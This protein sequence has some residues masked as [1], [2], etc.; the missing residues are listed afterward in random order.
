MDQRVVW[1]VEDDGDVARQMAALLADAGFGV[2]VFPDGLSV[3]N[4]F[5]GDAPDVLL[6]DWNLPDDA[7][8]SICRWVRRH[9]EALPVM[10]VTVRD[11][12]ADIVEGLRAG[13]DDYVTKPF[14]PDVLLGRIEALLRRTPTGTTVLAC[15]DVTLDR[16]RHR[17]AVGGEPVELAPL[18]YRILALLMERKG[19]LVS[20]DALRDQAWEDGRP[21]SDN[22]LTVTIK[23]LRAKLAPSDCLKTV[24]SFGYR[25]EEP[26]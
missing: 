10:M 5:P 13:A 17:V 12:P 22:A 2:R 20:R 25:M 24:R 6:V 23:R 18:E 26:R 21:V 15:G 8:P 14:H 16:E 3:R 19:R 11:D 9:D 1:Y 4:A 7:G